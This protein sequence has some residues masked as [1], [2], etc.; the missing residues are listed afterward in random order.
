[1]IAAERLYAEAQVA[2][3]KDALAKLDEARTK[4]GHA[5]FS[6]TAISAHYR[7]EGLDKNIEDLIKLV[8]NLRAEKQF[9][10]GQQQTDM[11]QKISED[12]LRIE[13]LYLAKR[14][15]DLIKRSYI[16]IHNNQ[17]SLSE[18][19]LEKV[20]RLDP[21]NK[22][23]EYLLRLV[24][25]KGDEARSKDIEYR[26]K[27]ETRRT[28][29]DADEF[30][31]PYHDVIIYPENWEE[32]DRNRSAFT[33][34]AT[35]EQ[36][37]WKKLIE[38]KME[39]KV[40]VSFD[41]EPLEEVIATLRSLVQVTIIVDADSLE[42]VDAP[43]ILT[44]DNMRFKTALEW[45]LRLANLTYVLKDEAIWIASPDR[46]QGDKIM[47]I[48][49]VR[50]LLGDVTYFIGPDMTLN[51]DE[52][53]SVD[54]P[55]Q[56]DQD[57][58]LENII[59]MIQEKIDP[60]SWDETSGASITGRE[61]KLIVTNT[62]NVHMKIEQMLDSFRKA[63]K[64]QVYIN[65]RFI[66]ITSDFLEDIG[67][68][69]QGLDRDVASDVAGIANGLPAGFSSDPTKR[70][71]GWDAYDLRGVVLNN[72][73]ANV[74]GLTAIPYQAG[75]GLNLQYALLGNFQA[76]V[77]LNAIQKSQKGIVLLAPRLTVFNTQRAYMM[78]AREE[79]YI[80]DYEGLIATQAA[81][82]DPV[83]KTFTVGM[84][85]DVRPIISSDRK[86]ITIELRPTQATLITLKQY[87]INAGVWGTGY[88]IYAPVI[89]LQKVRTTAVIPD[90]GILLLGGQIN[91][92]HWKISSG[93]PFL[94][95]L[96]IIGRLFSSNAETINKQQ[97]LIFINAR[98][99]MFEELEEQLRAR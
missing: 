82:L 96:P 18:L 51:P 99:L 77:I 32:I 71:G 69:W 31:I 74:L 62:T 35:E 91:I 20:V 6:L 14:I 42:G 52:G 86:Y 34:V 64:L 47:Q 4:L 80:A 11:A 45:V 78:V 22:E 60:S 36:P 56:P 66:T 57:E 97:L 94:S 75:E 87:N 53:I 30:M 81:I 92:S 89:E 98:I 68:T 23:A 65:A 76:E 49:D 16:A 8:N 13:E 79:S 10:A 3:G 59:N 38:A 73:T 9:E 93:I 95:K 7:P 85:L 28:W 27:L 21:G 70:T 26:T 54:I 5:K 41:E 55:E 29:Q 2:K 40:A 63:Q 37:E 43:I 67:V 88:E 61:G 33:E 58:Q 44:L 19:L 48:Y 72:S 15:D 50:D 12:I 24:Q 84:I 39:R 83:I 17:Y 46:I 1:M 90:N 25:K